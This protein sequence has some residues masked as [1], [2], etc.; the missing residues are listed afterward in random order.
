VPTDFTFL[1]PVD[2]AGQVIEELD[3]ELGQPIGRRRPAGKEKGPWRQI[4]TRI[5]SQAVVE[6]D[7]VQRMF[8]ASYP[9]RLHR[10]R[11]ASQMFAPDLRCA[12][13]QPPH[14]HRQRDARNCGVTGV[15]L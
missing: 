6:N 5:L 13:G 7:N 2:R 14:L 4:K 10:D 8:A 11:I 3:D 1:P 12:T 9:T 15:L